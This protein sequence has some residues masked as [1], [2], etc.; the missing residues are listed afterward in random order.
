MKGVAMLMTTPPETVAT[1]MVYI[2]HY[3]KTL[4]PFQTKLHRPILE[5][6]AGH[7]QKPTRQT[8]GIFLDKKL[9]AGIIPPDWQQSHMNFSRKSA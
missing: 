1:Q 9:G 4:I 8:R 7:H 5:G 3:T 6:P 2:L